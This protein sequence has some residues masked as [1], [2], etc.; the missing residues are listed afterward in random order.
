MAALGFEGKTQTKA[1]PPTP[2]P[3]KLPASKR[4]N[5]EEEYVKRSGDKPKL[6]LVVIG[7]SSKN[8]YYVTHMN[9]FQGMSM[10]ASRH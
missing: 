2:P 9:C 1:P 6:N 5:V 3:S 4:I 10:L 8:A 7:T